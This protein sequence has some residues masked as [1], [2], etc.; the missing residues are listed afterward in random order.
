[1]EVYW[2]LE[3]FLTVIRAGMVSRFSGHLTRLDRFLL[4]KETVVN[5]H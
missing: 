2:P 4:G 3:G 1:M 5:Y